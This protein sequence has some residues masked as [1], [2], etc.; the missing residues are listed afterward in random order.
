MTFDSAGLFPGLHLRS[1]VFTTDTPTPVAPVP[2]ELH[3]PLHRRAAGQLRVELHLRRRGRG[4]DAGLQPLR[5]RLRLLSGGDRHAPQHGRL[6]RAREARRADAAARLPR[7][8]STTCSSAASTPTTSRASSRTAITAG[9]QRRARRSTVPTCRSRGRRWRSSCG[10]AGTAS[11]AP[12]ACTAPVFADVPCPGGF[13]VDYIEGISA[14]GI[15]AGCGNG[16]YCP[17]HE[18][19]ERADG[20]VPRQGVRD[21]VRALDSERAA[22]RPDGRERERGSGGPRPLPGKRA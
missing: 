14:E 3:G 17:E 8:S 22:S 20:G 21:P 19:H 4:R 11:E 1:L 18:H 7:P 10:R 15:T 2:V 5:A 9:L 6:H 13:A 16:N 12:P